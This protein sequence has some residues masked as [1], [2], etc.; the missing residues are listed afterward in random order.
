M[1]N[2]LLLMTHSCQN[3]FVEPYPRTWVEI[4]FPAMANNLA[5]VKKRVGSEVKIGLVCKADAYGHGL[6][7]TGR[8]ASK[9]GADWLCVASIQEGVAL[10]DSGIECPVMVMSP[11]LPIE[12]G[13]AIFY[14]LDVLVESAEMIEHFQKTA[15]SQNRNA[16]I[17]LKVDT[18]LHRFGCDPS[19]VDSLVNL[20]QRKSNL[21]LRGIAQHFLNSAGNQARTLDQLQLFDKVLSSA[22]YPDQT[23]IHSANSAAT[24]LYA[25]S[26]KSLVRIGMHAY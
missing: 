10:R 25:D 18:G 3:T 15:A 5:V 23:L 13:Q 2:L 26:R 7:P 14:G 11:T 9:N 16:L 21:V 20:I 22:V 24:A 19:H 8:F 4:N 6:V 17:H 12:S 1:V